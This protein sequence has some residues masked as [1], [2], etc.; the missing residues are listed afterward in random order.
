MR[1]PAEDQL[2]AIAERGQITDALAEALGQSIAAYHAAA[3]CAAPTGRTSSAP[4]STNSVPP[5]PAWETS[6]GWC[7]STALSARRGAS[8]HVRRCH[9]DRHLRNLVLID[10]RPVTFDALELDGTLGTGDVLYGLAVLLVDLRHRN[11]GRAANIVLNDYLLAAAG[12]EDEGLAALPLFLAVRAA[13]RAMVD[14]EAGRARH[15]TG[16]S[17]SDAR[18]C[19][20]EASAALRP[21]LPRL[22]ALGGLSG[23]GKTTLA[24]RIAPLIGPALDAVHLRTDL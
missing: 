16:A 24:R 22:V 6:S 4:S 5:L 1:F 11:L 10:E 17:D 12:G 8:G 2:E 18:G 9:G 21:A 19:L 15:A 3:R 20:G 7:R 14:V 13:I 23:S